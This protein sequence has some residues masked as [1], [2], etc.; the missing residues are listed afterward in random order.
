MKKLAVIL[1]PN[2]YPLAGPFRY[3]IIDHDEKG[4]YKEYADADQARAQKANP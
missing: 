1:K 3:G 4:E 2:E